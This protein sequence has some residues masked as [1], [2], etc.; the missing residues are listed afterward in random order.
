MKA[1]PSSSKKGVKKKL[2]QIFLWRPN[3]ICYECA[4]PG[5]YNAN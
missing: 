4:N 3:M 5:D 2:W 1:I